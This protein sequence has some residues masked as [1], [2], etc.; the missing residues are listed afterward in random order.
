MLGTVLIAL[1]AS[2]A[3]QLVWPKID[4]RI[5]RLR[6]RHSVCSFSEGTGVETLIDPQGRGE[7]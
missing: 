7:V 2:I 5:T 3:V 4:R 1:A 6:R